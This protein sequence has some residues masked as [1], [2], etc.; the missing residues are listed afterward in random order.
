VSRLVLRGVDLTLGGREVLRA[1]DCEL[2]P[3][4]MLGIIGPNGAGKSSLLQVMAGLLR[5]RCGEVLLDD[6]PLAAW[7]QRAL[8]RR[9]AYLPQSAPVHWPLA[10]RTVVEL[11]RLPWRTGWFGADAGAARAVAEAMRL[12]EIEELA[13]RLV[14]ELSGGERMRVMVARVLA[15]EPAIILADEP[16][17]ALDAYHQLQVMEVLARRAREGL[18]VAVV[19]HDLGLAARFC[20]RLLL[21]DRGAVV[22]ADVPGRVLAPEL[23][24]PVYGVRM[25]R[26]DTDG[27]IIP[28]PWER[29]S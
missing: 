27:V 6:R 26:I 21:L 25:R 16:I 15:A 13:D 8:A 4:A 24:E 18:A 10:V 29:T 9:L 2:E 17:A 14:T 23:L 20:D 7:P 5:P 11:G 1:L 28:V 12:A 19:L 3:G 22:S